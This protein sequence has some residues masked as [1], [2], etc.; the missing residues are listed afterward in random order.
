MASGGSGGKGLLLLGLLLVVAAAGGANY[1]RNYEAELKAAG[2]RPYQGYADEELAALIEAYG[3]QSRQS[4]DRH[5]QLAGTR[6]GDGVAREAH[7]SEHL[8]GFEQAQRQGNAV[9]RSAADA[10]QLTSVLRELE[11]EQSLRGDGGAA[12]HLRRLTTL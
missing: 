7:I 11:R 5:Q 8:K 12:V 9:R 3:E 10:A 1:W 2:E 4:L 6:S